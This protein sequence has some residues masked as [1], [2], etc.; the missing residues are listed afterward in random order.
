MPWLCSAAEAQA[1]GAPAPT[2]AMVPFA[3]LNSGDTAWMLSATTLVLL[4]TLPGLALFYAGMVRKKNILATMAQV[5]AT[6]AL[7]SLLWFA[8]GYSLAFGSGTPWVGDASGLW[9]G[10]LG[11]DKASGQLSVHA[12]APT[13]PESVFAM[14]QMSF[15]I[16][17]PALIVG[18]FA[19]R[20]R[21]SALL[22]FM[23]LW[24]LGVYAPVAHWVWAPDGWLASMGAL[25][26]AGGTV[27][28]IN[29]GIAGLVAAWMVG[30]RVG[31]GQVALTPSNLGYTL[32]GAALL[33]VG[34]MGFNGGSA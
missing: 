17:T 6:C 8:L 30:P 15:A 22:W 1:A 11:Y 3:N 20:M 23:A 18:A 13:V 29:A 16:I 21:F 9:M 14:Y 33:W 26:F 2:S 19:E 12:L 7:V 4:M 31:Y 32:V 10:L 5:L 24:S 28:H 25:D 34:W 27:V